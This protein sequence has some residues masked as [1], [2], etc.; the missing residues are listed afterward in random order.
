M[1]F[2]GIHGCVHIADIGCIG[3][4]GAPAGHIGDGF[5]ARIDAIAIDGYRAGS[6]AG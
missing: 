2:S 1:R 4:G 3:S 6:D 5:V